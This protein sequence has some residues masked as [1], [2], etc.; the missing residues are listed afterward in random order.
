MD[1]FT[2]SVYSIL[3]SIA[4]GLDFSFSYIFPTIRSFSGLSPIRACPWRANRKKVIH[5]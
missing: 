3:P 4:G 5:H 2:S 1:I